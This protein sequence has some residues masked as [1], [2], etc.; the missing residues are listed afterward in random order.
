M[1]SDHR[2]S[3]HSLD[4]RLDSQ[5]H[6]ICPIQS[7]LLLRYEDGDTAARS[8]GSA[9]IPNQVGEGTTGSQR[10]SATTQTLMVPHMEGSDPNPLEGSGVSNPYRFCGTGKGL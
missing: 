4:S 5:A 10:V 3:D 1:T 8:G 9:A 6:E 7:Y 2:S